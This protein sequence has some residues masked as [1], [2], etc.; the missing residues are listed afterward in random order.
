MLSYDVSDEE[1][2]NISKLLI[3]NS[4]FA[5]LA[6]DKFINQQNKSF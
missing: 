2:A 6:T 3:F 1:K 4:K 5:S